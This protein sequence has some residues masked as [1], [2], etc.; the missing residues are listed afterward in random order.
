MIQAQ[1]HA[2]SRRGYAASYCGFQTVCWK[3]AHRLCPRYS[4]VPERWR[5]ECECPPTLETGCPMWESNN[6]YRALVTNTSNSES[7]DG[8]IDRSSCGKNNIGTSL[9]GR[10]TGG[11]T[12]PRDC[13]VT[14]HTPIPTVDW[15]D[16]GSLQTR[17]QTQN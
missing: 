16:I 9:R 15:L 14:G 13:V 3:T 10:S 12:L 8:D 2:C 7:G 5:F 17:T 1:S 6:E 4:R 11:L